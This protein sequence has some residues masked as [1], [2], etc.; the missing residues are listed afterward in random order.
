MSQTNLLSRRFNDHL[1]SLAC[2][3]TCLAC[4]YGINQFITFIP[5]SLFGMVILAFGLKI[6]LISADKLEFSVSW[7]IK[8]MGVCFVPAGVGI[9]EHFEL[10]K[11]DGP[12]MLLLTIFS[13]FLL[14][15]MVGWLYQKLNRQ[16]L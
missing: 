12:L 6:S 13:T 16:V 7:I 4:G 14:M 2:I 3:F 10:I 9:M 5:P 1:Y 8:H 15:Y 11:H